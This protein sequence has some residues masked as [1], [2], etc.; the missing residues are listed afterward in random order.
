MAAVNLSD[1][2]T[3]RATVQAHEAFGGNLDAL[4]ET[5]VD[6]YLRV[7][8]AV[9]LATGAGQAKAKEQ[10][11]AAAG[12]LH[13]AGHLTAAELAAIKADPAAISKPQDHPVIQATTKANPKATMAAGKATLFTGAV[14]A[15]AGPALDPRTNVAANLAATEAAI[16]D[17][18]EA[19]AQAIAASNVATAD[20]AALITKIERV[21]TRVAEIRG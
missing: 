10:I 14:R 16:V 4:T 9:R 21:A 11:I 12:A 15:A 17:P 5:A 2:L 20:V 19:A 18:V 13:D 6:F 8:Q 3:A 1:A 7:Q